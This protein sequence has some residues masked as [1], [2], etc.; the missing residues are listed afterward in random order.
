MS[1]P[2]SSA[3]RRFAAAGLAAAALHVAAPPANAQNKA[4]IAQFLSPGFPEELVS[5]KKADRIAWLGYEHGMRN[6]FAAAAPDFKPVRLTK[7]LDDDGVTLEELSISDDGSIVTFVR[8]SEPNRQGWI[9]NPS[10]NPNGG[11]RDIWAARTNGTGAWRMIEGNAPA[12]SPNGQSVLF[13]SDGQIFR[14]PTS[15]T[16]TTAQVDERELPFIKEWGRNS[17]PQWSPDGSKIA[18]V[19]ARDNHALIG[20]YDMKTRTVH[21][22]SPSVDFDGSP[23]WSADG[24]QLAFVRR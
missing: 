10:S 17:N 16:G 24:K 22:A 11:E 9:A 13:V 14:A 20:I 8:G 3:L 21:Y 5:A 1:Y 19:S 2:R 7:F 23:T 12:L 18:Y 15:R 6:V 4:T